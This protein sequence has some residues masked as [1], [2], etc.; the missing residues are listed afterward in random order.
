M[1]ADGIPRGA[2]RW[3]VDRLHVGAPESDI[4]IGIARL[5]AGADW[6]DGT[7]AIASRYALRAHRANRAR[8]ARVTSGYYGRDDRRPCPAG[9]DHAPGAVWHGGIG[10]RFVSEDG[11]D[12]CYRCGMY[13]ADL[14]C[15]RAILVPDCAGP[16]ADR[17]H[18]WTGAPDGI[19]C[20]HC[21][22]SIGADGRPHGP[23]SCPDPEDS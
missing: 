15:A 12:H 20:A 1:M 23:A 18:Y 8:Y 7:R 14:D 17:A 5:T 13:A 2:I 22:A 9:P 11:A 16:A 19:E 3:W 10:H 4:R 6:T 21:S